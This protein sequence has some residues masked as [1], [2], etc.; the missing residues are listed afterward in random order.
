MGFI[1]LCIA[2]GA[3]ELHAETY[4]LPSNGLEVILSHDPT[5]PRV[6]VNVWYHAGPANEPPGQA[7]I[8]HLL[9]R[10][11][12]RGSEHAPAGEHR[13]L[14]KRAGATDVDATTSFD[15]TNFY[16][17]VPSHQ[18]ELA[19][20]LES[21]RMGF[22]RSSLSAQAL[23]E[24][25]EVI[26]NERRQS[27]LDRPYGR[28]SQA[29]FRALFKKGHPYHGYVLGTAESL[30]ALTPEDTR[31]YYDTF[32]APANA[33]LAVVGDFDPSRVKSLVETYFGSLPS[34]PGP[35]PRAIVTPPIVE[36]IRLQ[37]P[38]AVELPRVQY[39]WHSAPALTQDDATAE[40]LA[41]ILGQGSG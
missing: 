34:R 3:P 28:S 27:I 23:D 36:E 11:M 32:Y 29:L 38:E 41:V 9:E 8:A 16:Q 35:K 6:A 39:G 13:Q 12:F 10:L 31:R 21:D 19:L 14:L 7:G 20:W 17:T 1:A 2:L 30:A 37:V 4:R 22:L 33:T 40:V 5:L 24:Q 15:R 18:L 26:R 25:R